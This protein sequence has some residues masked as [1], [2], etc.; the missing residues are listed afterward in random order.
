VRGWDDTHAS[1]ITAEHGDDWEANR[2]Y[3]PFLFGEIDDPGALA[4]AQQSLQE[5]AAQA[6]W[7]LYNS[8]N[9]LNPA[10]ILRLLDHD[11]LAWTS[12]H[13]ENPFLFLAAYIPDVVIGLHTLLRDLALLNRI[14]DRFPQFAAPEYST[15]ARS[16]LDLLGDLPRTCNWYS[17]RPVSDSWQKDLTSSQLQQRAAAFQAPLQRAWNRWDVLRERLGQVEKDTSLHFLRKLSRNINVA[18]EFLRD[19]HQDCE[20]AVTRMAQEEGT[21]PIRV[22]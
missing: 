2:L 8:G 17:W 15:T 10:Y 18:L 11:S 19:W 5:S 13:T 6:T 3:F 4:S 16:A 7:R 14:D 12:R 9:E 22:H 1:F 20:E 21:W